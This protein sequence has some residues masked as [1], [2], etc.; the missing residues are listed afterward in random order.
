MQ[1]VDEMDPVTEVALFIEREKIQKRVQ[2][3]CEQVASSL[4][5]V[6]RRVPPTTPSTTPPTIAMDVESDSV[7]NLANMDSDSDC[8]SDDSQKTMTYPEPATAATPAAVAAKAVPV[9]TAVP[10]HK[11]PHEFRHTSSA[12]SDNVSPMLAE[13][14]A[15]VKDRMAN[16]AQPKKLEPGM[17]SNSRCPFSRGGLYRQYYSCV[18]RLIQLENTLSE[19]LCGEPEV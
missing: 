11:F 3:R 1:S 14:Y 8:E 2:K 12:N 16:Y 18:E 17:C 4:F 7:I 6:Y 13:I 10:V 5:P 19:T 9:T 15:L